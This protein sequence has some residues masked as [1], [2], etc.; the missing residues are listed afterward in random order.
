[1]SRLLALID[2]YKD[3]HGQ[4]SDS[5]I[6]RVI[7]VAPQTISTWR[8]RGYKEPMDMEVLRK[9]AGLLGV[10]FET[11]VLRAV[12]LDV[13][14]IKEGDGDDGPQAAPIAT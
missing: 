8:H 11:V 7:G 5:S 9:L 6:G 1:M 14:W 10:D 4:P 3:R 13:G 2:D 12:L